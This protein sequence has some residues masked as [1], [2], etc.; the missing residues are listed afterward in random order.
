MR[1]LAVPNWS[2]PSKDSLSGKSAEHLLEEAR[3]AVTGLGVRIHF[4]SYDR[5]HARAV[6]AFSGVP[7]Q[8][9]AAVL[10]IAERILPEVDLGRHEGVH[11]RVGVL[12]V[13]PFVSL[14]PPTASLD[15]QTQ[16]IARLV[17]ISRTLAGEFSAKFKIP[18][19]LYEYAAHPGSPSSLPV[20]RSPKAQLPPPTFGAEFVG[21]ERHLK[22]GVSIFG[23]RDF[24][25]A[26][27]IDLATEDPLPSIQ[28]ARAIREGRESGD[29]RFVGVRALGFELP[30][31]KRT[32]VS[33]NF[34]KPNHSSFD[35]VYEFVE[36]HCHRLEVVIHGTELIG[37]IR[38]ADLE[39][40]KTLRI[41]SA[42]LVD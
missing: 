18:T 14:L 40:S 19:R 27:N 25:I 36:S 30:S 12:D 5:D 42:Q 1:F 28:I 22:N 35:R 4:W 8:M 2:L 20:L 26:A 7:G 33:M 11:P 37:V 31:V 6:T 34:T 38:N 29:T 21:S 32:Q 15:E 10:A 24:L 17:H 41:D 39:N 23:V 16:E 13:C 3:L 9:E